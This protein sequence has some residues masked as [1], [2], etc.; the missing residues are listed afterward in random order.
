MVDV[1]FACNEAGL[2]EEAAHLRR[3]LGHLGKFLEEGEMSERDLAFSE[4]AAFER[5]LELR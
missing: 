3:A 5:E 4:L 2:Q 1:I